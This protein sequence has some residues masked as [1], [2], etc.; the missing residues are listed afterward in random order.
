MKL[1]S[2]GF[3]ADTTAGSVAI[4]TGTTTIHIAPNTVTLFSPVN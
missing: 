2:S 1:L 4:D 3:Y